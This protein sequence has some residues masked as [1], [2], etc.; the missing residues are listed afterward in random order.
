[1]RVQCAVVSDQKKT[2]F[3]YYASLS[4]ASSYIPGHDY[5][6]GIFKKGV[7]NAL[8]LFQPCFALSSFIFSQTGP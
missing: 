2:F 3:F 5:L 6:F 8:I 7:P 1:M 4:D